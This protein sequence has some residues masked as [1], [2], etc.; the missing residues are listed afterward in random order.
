MSEF[1]GGNLNRVVRHGVFETN[2]SSSH[3]ISIVGGTYKPDTIPVIDGIC[4]IYGGEFGW[5]IEQYND[6]ATK[7]SYCLVF[8]YGDS[9][10]SDPHVK[11]APLYPELLEMLRAVV[12][13]RVGAPVEFD[14]DGWYYIDHQSRDRRY[15]DTPGDEA[16]SSPESLRDFIFNPASEL[17]IDHDN[18]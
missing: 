1:N 13:E 18:H 4:R 2:S 7:A 9:D 5:G 15:R 3:S 6:A 16:F 10:F 11:S 12:A 14:M 17:L 8:A